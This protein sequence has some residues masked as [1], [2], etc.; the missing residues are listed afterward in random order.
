[1]LRFIFQDI[2]VLYPV[3]Q[4]EIKVYKEKIVIFNSLCIII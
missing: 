3:Y 4:L 1:M 2:K